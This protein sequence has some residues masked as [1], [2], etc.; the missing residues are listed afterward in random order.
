MD[1]NQAMAPIISP[2]DVNSVLTSGHNVTGFTSKSDTF[3]NDMP[4]PSIATLYTRFKQIKAS[5]QLGS[6]V[7]LDVLT[8]C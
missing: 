4:S 3:V 8:C 5:E 7:L 6:V 2:E 1:R